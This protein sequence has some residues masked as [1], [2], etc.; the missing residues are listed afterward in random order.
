[1]IEIIKG[2]GDQPMY[3]EKNK[4]WFKDYENRDFHNAFYIERG[5]VKYD[6]LVLEKD[7]KYNA[8][9]VPIFAKKYMDMEIDGMEINFG[10]L[11]RASV[12]KYLENEIDVRTITNEQYEELKEYTRIQKENRKFLESL[13]NEDKEILEYVSD[14]GY[15]LEEG[16]NQYGENITLSEIR[17]NMENGFEMYRVTCHSTEWLGLG[18]CQCTSHDYYELYPISYENVLNL[19]KE[20][21]RMKEEQHQQHKDFIESLSVE[22]RELLKDIQKNGIDLEKTEN[23]FGETIVTKYI[24]PSSGKEFEFELVYLNCHSSE[25]EGMGTCQCSNHPTW[26]SKKITAKEVL[27][28]VRNA[29]MEKEGEIELEL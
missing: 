11:E 12:Q 21:I 13:S 18:T 20:D 27:E 5:H 9:P 14:T 3:V 1:M 19:V 28:N 2:K 16:E 22:D 7:Q 23:Q 6:L 26:E 24:S 15:T 10:E 4:Q 8:I 25:Q 17:G 29:V